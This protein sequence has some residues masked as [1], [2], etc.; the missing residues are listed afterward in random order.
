[1]SVLGY[2]NARAAAP[3]VFLSREASRFDPVL[4]ES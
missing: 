2:A 3:F 1:M 4:S